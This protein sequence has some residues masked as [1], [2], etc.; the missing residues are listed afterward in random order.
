METLVETKYSQAVKKLRTRKVK[1]LPIKRK[2]GWVPETHDSAFMN[3]G[4]RMGIVV[5]VLPGNILVDPLKPEFDENDRK[6]LASELGLTGPEQ[7][8]VYASKGYW[9]NRSVDLDKGVLYLNLDNIEDLIKFLIL[10]ADSARISPTWRERFN[11]GTYKFAIIDEGQEVEEN[12]TRTE[13]MKKA[14]QVFGRMDSSVDK[15]KDFLYVY[16]LNKKEAKRPARNASTDYLK[17]EI[18]KVIDNDLALFLEITSD[19]RYETRLLVVKAT[20]AGALLRNKQMYTLPGGEKPIGILEDVIDF[21]DDDRNQEIRI[22]LIHQVGLV[23]K[24]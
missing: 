4:A 13:D 24:S 15:M 1:I 23:N 21:L 22:K 17:A 18:Q 2:G 16:Y 14:Y 8:N 9:R 10:R 6:C 3:D 19:V 11:S 20:E 7:F 12:V 5:P